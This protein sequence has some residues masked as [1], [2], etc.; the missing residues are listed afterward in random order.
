M[1]AF[2]AQHVST[3]PFGLRLGVGAA[4]AGCVGD[5]CREDRMP[6]DSGACIPGCVA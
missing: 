4:G 3:V 1:C 2:G 5:I 6:G